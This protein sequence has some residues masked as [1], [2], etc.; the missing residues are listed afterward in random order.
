MTDC[1][2]ATLRANAFKGPFQGLGATL[3]RNVP[4]NSIYLGS[5]EVL[6]DYIARW[7]GIKKTELGGRESSFFPDGAPQSLGLSPHELC[8]QSRV[9]VLHCRFVP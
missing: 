6:K 5:F 4:A 3:V 7:Q 9:L 2:R 8:S 1:V